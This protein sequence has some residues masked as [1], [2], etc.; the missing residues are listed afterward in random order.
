MSAAPFDVGGIAERLR[1][2]VPALRSVG[3]AGD[4][5]AVRSI[6]DFPAPC[7]YVLLASE[8]GDP[9]PIGAA[10]RGQVIKV[11]QLAVVTFGVVIAARNYREQ[12]GGQLSSEFVQ[13]LG[14]TRAAVMGYVPELSGARP[15]QWQ[16]GRLLDY[17]AAN[18]LWLDTFI[19][20]HFIG[21]N[22]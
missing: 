7:A 6:A 20:Q 4:L 8:R 3:L 21:S 11:R 10:V 5:G 14:A 22:P 19:T 18:G 12:Q 1:D 16:E 17:D 9:Q 13:L 2:L 15:I